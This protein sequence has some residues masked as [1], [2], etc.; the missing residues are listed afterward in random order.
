MRVILSCAAAA[1]SVAALSAPAGG[2][3]VRAEF[4]SMS[5][6]AGHC[7]KGTFPDSTTTDR[8]C[9]SWM[10]GGKFLRDRHVVH[11]SDGT[12][13]SLGETTYLWDPKARELQYLYIESDGGVLRGNVAS[14]GATLKFPE[15]TY[16]DE[17]KE[18][19]VRSRWEPA[20]ASAYDVKTEFRKGGEWV[21]GFS[22]HMR[23]VGPS[24]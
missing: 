1:A 11:R 13:D 12:P 3:P 16:S 9:F 8:H 20:G 22:V 2:E 24:S 19:G 14:E 10:Y 6:L 18:I 23:L 5:F 7:W 15:S 21:P 17:G 4:Q